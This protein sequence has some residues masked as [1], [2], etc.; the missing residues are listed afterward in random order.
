MARDTSTNG[1]PRVNPSGGRDHFSKAWSTVLAGGGVKGGQVVGKTSADG[2]EVA[3]RPV[4]GQDFLAT[5]GLALG[6]DITKPN[7]S[8]IGR[9]VRI[10]EPT[11]KPIKEVVA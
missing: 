6:V 8:N 10:T 5:V 1:T 7:V 3:E 2:T 9:P 11:A 4:D